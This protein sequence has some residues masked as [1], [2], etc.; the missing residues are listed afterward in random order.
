MGS[1][2]DHKCKVLIREHNARYAKGNNIK[3]IL[4]LMEDS[5]YSDDFKWRQ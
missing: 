4:N 1:A 2:Q 3:V 5:Q